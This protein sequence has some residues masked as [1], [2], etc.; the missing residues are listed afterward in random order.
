MNRSDLDAISHRL[1][2]LKDEL[3]VDIFPD[4][5]NNPDGTWQPG[6]W[7]KAE[8]DK[9]H[10][11]IDLLA[12]AMGGN[13]NF[14]RNIGGVQFKKAN[15]GSHGGEALL[16]RVSLSEKGT[17]TA[18]TVIHELAHTW[19]ANHGWRLSVALEKF[20]GGLTSP[21][22]S[23]FK[24]LV[25]WRD[26]AFSSPEDQPG[27]RG[28][29]PGCNKAGYFYGDQPSGSN[30]AFNRKE[31]FAESVAMYAGWDRDNELSKQAHARVERY[32][33]PNGARDPFFGMV[34]DWADYARY[35]YP[36]N[37]DYGKTKR[38]EFIDRLV[39]GKITLP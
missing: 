38:W 18:W 6:R 26:S 17:F 21:S 13:E 28:R 7:T 34:D 39:H 19:D 33:L 8:L 2:Q 30:W 14:I 36:A 1:A 23:Y 27:R 9:L 37:G 24:R 15:I 11:H 5:G 31:D 10:H 4:W 29:L 12:R 35:F 32:L 25:G 22:L 16:H 20:T 3:Q